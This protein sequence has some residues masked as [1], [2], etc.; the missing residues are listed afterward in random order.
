MIRIALLIVLFA[1]GCGA[2]PPAPQEKARG[3]L[4]AFFGVVE[5]R[6]TEQGFVRN[7]DYPPGVFSG[8][9][10]PRKEP[11][12]LRGD[13]IAFGHYKIQ[14]SALFI[15]ATVT[16]PATFLYRASQADEVNE[17]FE[18]SFLPENASE[19]TRSSITAIY[20]I[21]NG[22]LLRVLRSTTTKASASTRRPH[23]L[24]TRTENGDY[25]QAQGA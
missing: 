5:G 18:W 20:E 10:P 12:V 17:P 13:E 8:E 14:D 11:D 23:F 19:K 24:F 4:T 1:S 3:P 25:W 6:R 16:Q 2:P 7:P 22:Y 21:P 15:G 9:Y